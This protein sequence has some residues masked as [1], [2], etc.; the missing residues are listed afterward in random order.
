MVF[1]S[2]TLS[3]PVTVWR[4]TWQKINIGVDKN[5]PSCCWIYCW[6]QEKSQNF[7]ASFSPT[8]FHFSCFLLRGTVATTEKRVRE[9]LEKPTTIMF[10]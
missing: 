2:S 9:R 6:K 4:F 1:F 10:R 7:K 5:C 3:S 8:A